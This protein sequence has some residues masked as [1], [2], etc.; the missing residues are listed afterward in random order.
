MKSFAVSLILATRA[1]AWTDNYFDQIESMSTSGAVVENHNF[2]DDSFVGGSNFG[3]NSRA[4]SF[5]K[6]S[7]YPHSRDISSVKPA[8]PKSGRPSPPNPRFRGYEKPNMSA[9]PKHS[10]DAYKKPTYGGHRFD[11]YGDSVVP[12]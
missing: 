9:E 3:R 10:H 8:V 6:Y 7:S 11:R 12:G 4:D 5:S 2:A 1:T